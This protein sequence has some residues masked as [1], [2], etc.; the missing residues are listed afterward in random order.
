L[1]WPNDVLIGHQKLAGILIELQ[2][3]MDGP[4]AA[5]IGIG[6]NLRMPPELRN[7]IDQPAIDLE[8]AMQQEVNPNELLAL[9]LKSLSCVLQDFEQHGFANLRAEWTRYH[10]YQNK[11]VRL[12]LPNGSVLHGIVNGVARDGFL[13]VNTDLGEQRFSVGEIS[14]RGLI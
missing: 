1:K 13:L 12:L 14:L 11:P 9:I 8:S 2:G 5:V 6:I 10:A 3:D 4:S 7:C